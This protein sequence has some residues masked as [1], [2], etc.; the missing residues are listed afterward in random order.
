MTMARATNK[1][2]F[3]ESILP[4]G[5]RAWVSSAGL[6]HGVRPA[7]PRGSHPDA[8]SPQAGSVQHYWVMPLSAPHIEAYKPQPVK[9][10]PVI[11]VKREVVKPVPKP[12]EVSVVVPKP[13]IYTPV[14]TKPVVKAVVRKPL[15]GSGC[16]ISRKGVP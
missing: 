1:G 15:T 14:L 4:Q 13:K 3:E 6:C 11:K 2:L 7:V 10:E 12:V 16:G 9:P 8:D 5:S